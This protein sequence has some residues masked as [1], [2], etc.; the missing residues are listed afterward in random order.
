MGSNTAKNLT[1]ILL[2]ILNT[3]VF[4][5]KPL[6]PPVDRGPKSKIELIR[7]D[8]LV[9]ENLNNP[10]RTFYGHVRFFHRGVFLDCQK[11]IHN[12]GSNNLVAYGNILINQGDSLTITGDTLYY[13]GNTR[14]AEIHGRKVILKDGETTLESKRLDYDLNQDLAYYPRPGVIHQDSVVLSSNSG[15]YNTST[16]VFNYYG[17]VEILHPDFV[18]CTDTLDYDS[19]IHKAE[20]RTPTTIYS[21]DGT[22]K[23]DRGY[24][25]TDSKKSRFFGRSYVE[26]EEYTL[27]ADTLDFDTQK[28]EGFGQGHVIFF[29][30]AD[31]LYLYGDYGEKKS[32]QGFTKMTGN[33]LMQSISDGDTLFLRAE[34]IIAYNSLDS[35]L[36]RNNKNDADSLNIAASDSLTTQ[37]DSTDTALIAP[38]SS[39]TDTVRNTD[40]NKI[41]FLIADGDVKIFRKDFQAVCDSLN[42]NLVDSVITFIVNPM[43]WSSENQLEG[44]TILVLMK[45][46]KINTM[47]LRQKSFVIALDSVENF[48]Q[49]KGREIVAYF[50]KDTN[51][52]RVLVDGN[53]ESIYFAMN[54][55]N[56]V[57][58]LN[59][60]ECSKMSLGF[61]ER[62]VKRILF[63]GNPESKLIPP[64]EINTGDMKLDGFDWKM[65]QKP[66]KE[67]VVGSK[68]VRDIAVDNEPNRE[69]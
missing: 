46:N 65:D 8:S 19:N 58:G 59:R 4:A 42:Y 43:I 40:P 3:T 31:S 34:Y 53:G 36:H 1:V 52:D 50:D 5:Q 21:E 44:D 57:I 30:K 45:K 47:F 24:Y 54:E 6:N 49:I 55:Q 41:Q 7:A 14:L 35:V 2:L 22:L 64:V 63:M 51:I 17:N 56:Q 38:D 28:E 32:D 60:V 20:F 25:F 13:D 15:Y 29:S 69:P 23:A 10:L 11:A 61:K 37:I 66:T 48:N 18:L 39:F 9:G 67:E 26:N 16:K 27:E 62:K 12:G 68:F 33:T